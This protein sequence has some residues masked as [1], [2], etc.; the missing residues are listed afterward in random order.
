MSRKRRLPYFPG[1]TSDFVNIIFGYLRV[2][3]ALAPIVRSVLQF[4]PTVLF[5]RFP[6]EMM[7]ICAT[8]A[9]IPAIMRGVMFWRGR[10][11]V[12]CSANDPR[13]AHHLAI[14]KNFSVSSDGSVRPDQTSYRICMRD[15]AFDEC[16]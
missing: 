3:M 7:R 6:F 14:D 2:P 5:W 4:V 13:G 16:P 1:R 15:C 11:P 9:A 10:F 12:D 8:F